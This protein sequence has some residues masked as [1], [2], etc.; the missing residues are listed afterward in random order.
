MRANGLWRYSARLGVYCHLPEIVTEPLPG[1]IG[2]GSVP[3][4]LS[5]QP[6]GWTSPTWGI[7]AANARTLADYI[8]RCAKRCEWL[9]LDLSALDFIGTAGFS[10]LRA[11]DA[12]CARAGICW[13]LVSGPAV[14]RLLRVCDPGSRLPVTQSLSTALVSVQNPRPALRPVPAPV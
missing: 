7:D 9:V 2:G 4:R 10:T 14:T 3:A 1:S 12:R 11:I 8:Q 5:S 13:T 6:P